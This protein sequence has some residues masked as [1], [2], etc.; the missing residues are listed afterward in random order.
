M[1]TKIAI[2]LLTGIKSLKYIMLIE[3]IKQNATKD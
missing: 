1:V 2:N 3:N